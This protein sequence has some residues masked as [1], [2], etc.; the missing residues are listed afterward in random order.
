MQYTALL[1]TPRRGIAAFLLLTLVSW[2]LG[3]PN[4]IHK[5]NAAALTFVSDTLS[6]TATSSPS[7]HTI[8]FTTPTGIAAGETFTIQF[9]PTDSA[10]DLS[11][12]DQTDIDVSDAVAGD[13]TIVAGAPGAGEWGYTIAGDTMTF[14]AGAGLV[15]AANGTTT[16]EIGTNAT[17]G[18]AGDA[19]I[20]NPDG[21]QASISYVIRIGGT[22]ADSADTRVLMVQHVELTAAVETIF[23]FEVLGVVAGE[24]INGDEVTAVDSTSVT[25]PFG[26]LTPGNDKTLGQELRVKTNATHG[27]AVTVQADGNLLSATGADINPFRDDAAT[28]VPEAWGVDPIATLDDDTT[29]GH[30]GITSEDADL[31]GNEFGVAL[32]AGNFIAAPRVVLSHDGPVTWAGDYTTPLTYNPDKA[33]TRVGYKIEITA[34]QEAATDYTQSLHYVATPTF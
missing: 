30:E 2:S 25:L 7:N 18:V 22:M 4:F 33:T 19:Q 28:A 6:D 29:Y 5:A 27:Y 3:L 24:A 31:N 23:E 17:F 34:L 15:V 1:N 13:K 8:V 11:A 9:D 21:T 20:V 16:V 10:F 14:T 32:F 12:V 26:I